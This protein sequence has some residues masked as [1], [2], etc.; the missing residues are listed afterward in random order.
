MSSPI[1]I[2]DHLDGERSRQ[3][4]GSAMYSCFGVRWRF[5]WLNQDE[6]GNSPLRFQVEADL[7]RQA[8]GSNADSKIG[9]TYAIIICM[10]SREFTTTVR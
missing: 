4:I 7:L 6:R 9:K 2:D 5:G 10:N 3:G 1:H 8:S